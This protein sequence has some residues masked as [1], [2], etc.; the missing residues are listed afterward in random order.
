M[1]SVPSKRVHTFTNIKIDEDRVTEG[2]A[3]IR[4]PHGQVFYNPVQQF[5]R[6]LSVCAITAFQKMFMADP[7]VQKRSPEKRG[8]RILEAL[9]ATGLRAVRYAREIAG[10]EAI[11]ANDLDADAVKLI[12]LNVADNHVESIVQVSHGDA[13]NVLH[14]EKAAGKPYDVIDLDPYGSAVPFV[15]AAMANVVD[16]GLLC[17]TCT[18]TAVLCASYV[19]TCFSKYG[20]IP[21][22]GDVAHEVALRILLQALEAAASRH[23]KYIQPLLACSIDFYVRVFIRVHESPSESKRSGLKQSMVYRCVGCK[24]TEMQP[25]MTLH[26][27]GR[28]EKFSPGHIQ[29][30]PTCRF[31]GGRKEIAGPLWNGPLHDLGFIAEVQSVLRDEKVQAHLGTVERIEGMLSLCAEELPSPLYVTLNEAASI[32]KTSCPPLL[33]VKSAFL[34]AGHRVSI[35]HCDPRAIKTDAPTDFF[36]ATMKAW[37][38]ET[39]ALDL[40]KIPKDSIAHRILTREYSQP[41]DLTRHEA[42]NPPSRKAGLTRFPENPVPFWG[43]KARAKSAKAN[44]THV[45]HP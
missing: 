27:K 1:S 15:D 23:K 36:W 37:I 5:N 19:E 35:S 34:N 10:V 24:S 38:I 29:L 39:K 7:K 6:D 11:L 33:A 4:Q 30:D 31:C 32:L 9:S 43:P 8:V 3:V 14:S 2:S 40:N 20:A 25:L 18:D 12:G 17:V 28:S 21:L 13:V 26:A 22:K 42:A 45:K 16:G 44:A 41:V